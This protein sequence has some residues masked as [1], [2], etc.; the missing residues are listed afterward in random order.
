MPQPL[1]AQAP[2]SEVLDIRRYPNRRLY[3]AT[4]SKGVTLDELHR[5]VVEGHRIKVTET[6]SGENITGKILTQIILDL[7]I[8]KLALFPDGLLHA[9]LQMN[10]TMMR[11]FMDSHFHQALELFSR[12]REQ[13]EAQWQKTVPSNAPQEW[14]NT[15]MKPFLQA[16]QLAPSTPK[17]SP[18]DLGKIVQNLSRQVAELQQEMA[19]QRNA[20]SSG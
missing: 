6:A 2:I 13:Y 15:W 7:D 19:N 20:K 17:T 9:I 16:A 10:E 8:G 14:M 12:S 3:D 4:R 5:L 11:E 18:D 1:P